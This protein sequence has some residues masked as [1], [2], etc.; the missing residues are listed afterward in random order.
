MPLPPK[1]VIRRLINEVAERE[2]IEGEIGVIF[3][4]DSYMARLN[5]RFR[6]RMGA[7]DV[8]SFRLKGEFQQDLLGEIYISVDR[9]EVQAQEYAEPFEREIRRL[10]L[11]GVLHLAGYSH[12]Q[13]KDRES[14]Y[15]NGAG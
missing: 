5:R 11:H 9:A 7:T 3:V 8:L 12:D 4:D 1:K 2:G 14:I 10:V 15:L 6:N 13:M